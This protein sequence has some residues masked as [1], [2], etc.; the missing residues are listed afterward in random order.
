MFLYEQKKKTKSNAPRDIH[1][2]S[3]G[4]VDYVKAIK[5]RSAY[6]CEQQKIKT[7]NSDVI[8][9]DVIFV[10]TQKGKLY[11]NTIK[12]TPHG[13]RYITLKTSLTS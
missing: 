3:P 10:Q 9:S 8:L 11:S 7:D 1:K 13:H 12:T 6:I 2:T 5:H 4:T